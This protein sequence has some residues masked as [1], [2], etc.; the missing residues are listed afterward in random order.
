MSDLAERVADWRRL[1]RDNP[2]DARTLLKRE[3][4]SHPSIEPDPPDIYR[5]S[6]RKTSRDCVGLC[7]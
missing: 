6:W 1:L 2:S 3:F 5:G 7:R 4:P